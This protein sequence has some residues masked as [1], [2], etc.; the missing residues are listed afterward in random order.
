MPDIFQYSE[1]CWA[2]VIMETTRSLNAIGATARRNARVL[3]A[4]ERFVIRL[5]GRPMAHTIII[6]KTDNDRFREKVGITGA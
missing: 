4:W 6:I 1:R 3:Q 2:S 5:L